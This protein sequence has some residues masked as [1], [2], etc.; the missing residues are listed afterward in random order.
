MLVS[1]SAA[2]RGCWECESSWGAADVRAARCAS[3]SPA[4]RRALKLRVRFWPGRRAR[5]VVRRLTSVLPPTRVTLSPG[6]NV[7]EKNCRPGV[8]LV[9]GVAGV[10]MRAG[11]GRRRGACASDPQP[12]ADLLRVFMPTRA[13]PR[14]NPVKSPSLATPAAYVLLRSRRRRRKE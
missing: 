8:A 9:P 14:S 5:A 6:E 2:A 13:E 12:R 3:G 4:A 10:P 7:F 11:V 1:D